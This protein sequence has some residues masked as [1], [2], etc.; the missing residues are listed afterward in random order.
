MVG[1]PVTIALSVPPAVEPVKETS[2]LS[3]PATASLKVALNTIGLVEVG[4]TCPPASA[5][6]TVGEGLSTSCCQVTVLVLET[7]LGLL[8]ASTAAAAGMVIATSP[9]VVMP[10]TVI[11]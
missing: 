10:L 7:R 6:L 3:N 4:E 9:L 11:V 5:V 1:P 8:A 2:V